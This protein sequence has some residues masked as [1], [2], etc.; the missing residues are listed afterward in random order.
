MQMALKV[1]VLH[2]TKLESL[3]EDKHSG[4]LG[5]F[6]PLFKVNPGVLGLQFVLYW[7]Y[8]QLFIFFGNL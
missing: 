2:Y 6:G 1:R 7:S 8:S 5:S 4:L 3:A